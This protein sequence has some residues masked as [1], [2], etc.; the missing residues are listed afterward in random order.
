MRIQLVSVILLICTLPRPTF[1]RN[2]CDA[3]PSS[4]PM[5]ENLTNPLTALPKGTPPCS[6]TALNPSC[7]IM[8]DRMN[9]LAPATV[10]TRRQIYQD[11]THMYQD[12]TRIYF[13]VYD[14]SPFEILSLDVQSATAQPRPDVFASGF[15]AL[16]SA[17]TGFQ[18]TQIALAPGAAVARGSV[19]SIQ[20]DQSALLL[21]MKEDLLAPALPALEQIHGVLKPMPSNLCPLSDDVRRPWTDTVKW[22]DDVENGLQAG[23]NNLT[24]AP[25]QNRISQLD[26]RITTLANQHIATVNDILELQNNQKTLREALKSLGT[27]LDKIRP[28]L[29]AL[30][31]QIDTI[32]PTNPDTPWIVTID[33]LHPS[34]KND[35]NE[36]W[37]L[38]YLNKLSGIAKRVS[39]DT[40]IEP[41]QALLGGLADSPSK[42]TITPLT[43]QFLT[44]NRLEIS[45][46]VLVPVTP[47]HS[48]T[49]VQ[50]FSSTTAVVQENETWAI[51]PDASFNFLLG[52]ELVKN[53]QRVA[54][55]LTGAVGYTT[56]NST[57]AF[58]AGPSISWR[59][60][61][62]SFL[63]D[64]GRDTELAG[65]YTVNHPLPTG[66]TA[67]QTKNFWDVKFA[68]GLS[69]RI[70]LGGPSH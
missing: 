32:Q 48:Y 30:K 10:Y 1:G 7:Y 68:P 40:Y 22:K 18:I 69:V 15:S 66:A 14:L 17:L 64:V 51:V 38:N 61:V 6:Y 57:V 55:F 9:P 11:K 36:V 24:T 54:F 23:I 28:K 41:D 31:S 49:A 19:V 8:V 42:Q 12:K 29:E 52:H 63:A 70:P 16:S 67:P 37:N 25:F 34:D 3:L 45:A 44:P 56:T 5:A 46:G 60:I 13:V 35:Q 21:A 27:V 2:V 47:Y 20:A 58:G 50:P 65:G 59:S 43:A 33:D 26:T 39:G 62:V 4:P 53:R